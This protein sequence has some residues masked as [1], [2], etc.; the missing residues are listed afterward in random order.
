LPG[1]GETSRSGRR[2]LVT[3]RW[4]TIGTGASGGK[5]LVYGCGNLSIRLARSAE[6]SQLQRSAE[7]SMQD[8]SGFFSV[9][10]SRLSQCGR[11]WNASKISLL[12][13]PL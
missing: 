1:C 3:Y 4:S 11:E 5:T 8:A 7:L 6:L 9:V 10:I 2:P 12:G 13:E